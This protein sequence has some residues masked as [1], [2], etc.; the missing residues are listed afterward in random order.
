MEPKVVR[1]PVRIH[2]NLADRRTNAALK[3]AC[4]PT[5][6][7]GAAFAQRESNDVNGVEGRSVHFL[8]WLELLRQP[9]SSSWVGAPVTSAHIC[10]P[11]WNP[12]WDPACLHR[13]NVDQYRSV[14]AGDDECHD[15]ADSCGAKALAI[16]CDVSLQGSAGRSASHGRRSARSQPKP[17]TVGWRDAA[18]EAGHLPPVLLLVVVVVVVVVVDV[19]ACP[20]TLNPDCS[21]LR[22]P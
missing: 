16:S 6:V 15:S 17:R 4:P 2:G 19:D 13:N 21:S 7:S 20:W 3:E 8:G 18:A 5:P 22:I 10:E 1:S 14:H 11:T 9:S 12:H